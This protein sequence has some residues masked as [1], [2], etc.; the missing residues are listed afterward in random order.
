MDY[1]NQCVSIML[2]AAQVLQAFKDCQ[3]ESSDGGIDITTKEFQDEIF[4]AINALITG[5]NNL[6]KLSVE[7]HA[8]DADVLVSKC[9]DCDKAHEASCTL[10]LDLDDC[11]SWDIFKK[12]TE[13]H[14][15]LCI[16]GIDNTFYLP[17]ED[18]DIND[19]VKYTYAN[20]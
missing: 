19:E 8:E 9:V 5:A 10:Y 20:K 17:E 3:E 6:Y 1:S 13:S 15:A 2:T 14:S 12:Y 7:K 16:E 4:P 11:I 18:I